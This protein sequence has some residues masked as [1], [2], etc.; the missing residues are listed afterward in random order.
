[1]ENLN[2]DNS[3]DKLKEL[4]YK[5][6]DRDIDIKRGLL[7]IRK[8]TNLENLNECEKL[9]KIKKILNNIKWRTL[10]GMVGTNT[11]N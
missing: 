2:K 7:N 5:L 8:I 9:D 6:T 3:I 4:S 10:N 1:M 11:Q